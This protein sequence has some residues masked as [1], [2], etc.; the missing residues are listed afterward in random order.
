MI[1]DFPDDL[2]EI[3][4]NVCAQITLMKVSTVQIIDR[5]ELG[6]AALPEKISQRGMVGLPQFPCTQSDGVP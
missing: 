2:L 4:L 3:P 6:I 5:P 1:P